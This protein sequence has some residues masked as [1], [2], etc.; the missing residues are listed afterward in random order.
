MEFE[1]KP[2]FIADLPQI[3]SVDFTPLEKDYLYMRLTSLG[4]FILLAGS[5]VLLASLFNDWPL[6]YGFYPFLVFM[7]L[8]LAIQWLGFCVKGY[9]LR[10][11]D[12]S[13]RSGLIFF[14]FTTVPFNRIQH[15]E[16]SQG[17]LGKLFD[18]ASVNVYTAGGSGSDISVKGLKKEDAQKLRDF[19]IKLSA[20]HE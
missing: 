11:K 8:L 14:H 12:I 1:N 17:A 7:I 16:V 18:L 15:C 5:G 10:E 13:Y 19:I 9:A 2:L 3:E 6:Y 4:L 20:E